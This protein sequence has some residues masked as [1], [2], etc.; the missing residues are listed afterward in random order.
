MNKIFTLTFLLG[1]FLLYSQKKE[2]KL[3]QKL[4]KQAKI[5]ESKEILS[6][7]GDLILNSSDPKLITQYHLLI[8]QIAKSQ[9]EFSKAFDNFKLAEGN[10][11]IKEILKSEIDLLSYEIQ[12]YA[13][14]KKKLFLFGGKKK[15][16]SSKLLQGEEKHFLLY[17]V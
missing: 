4:F 13:N 15:E 7:N 10:K 8:G 14:G 16:E 9:R 17:I 2:L 12:T 6:S 3:A 1:C 5:S 11:A